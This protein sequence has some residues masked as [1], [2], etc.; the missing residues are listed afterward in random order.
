MRILHPVWRGFWLAAAM[1]AG[2][3]LL[4]FADS[5]APFRFERRMVAYAGALTVGAF[6]GD[7]LRILRGG[8]LFQRTTW[9]R[10]LRAFLC[11]GGMAL[12]IGFAGDGRILPALLTGSPGAYA[13]GGMAL[14]AGFITT[15]IMGRKG[16]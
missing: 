15:R 5:L 2:L 1:L 16:A 12:A 11:G 10:C 4:G 3:I 6:L 14:L 13:F 7:L 9:Q 8:R